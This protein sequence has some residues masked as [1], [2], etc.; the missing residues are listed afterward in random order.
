MSLQLREGTSRIAVVQEEKTVKMP[1]PDRTWRA[2]FNTMFA[3]SAT[4][5]YWDED[6]A[7]ETS[8][9]ADTR[10][11]RANQ[12]EAA[13][14]KQLAG[15]VTPTRSLAWGL[16]AIQDTTADTGL[17]DEICTA[18]TDARLGDAVYK[19]VH[20]F[21]QAANYGVLDGKVVFRDFGDPGAPECLLEHQ[22]T[23]RAMLDELTDRIRLS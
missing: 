19:A 16:F 3:T 12:N 18:V 14:A 17:T 4:P 15:M 1:Y 10:G 11:W 20:T 7:W 6:A 5:L 9:V 8:Y 23:V 22:E 2:I 13:Y 21:D